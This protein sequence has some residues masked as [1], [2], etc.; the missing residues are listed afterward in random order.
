MMLAKKG[1]EEEEVT[2]AE[3]VGMGEGMGE[4]VGVG[5][6]EGTMEEEMEGMGEA[7]ET[8]DEEVEGMM[9]EEVG[10]G[11]AER[12]AEEEVEGMGE[13]V[14]MGGVVK[15]EGAVEEEVEGMMGLG[16][17]EGMVVNVVVGG[18]GVCNHHVGGLRSPISRRPSVR[19]RQRLRT[20]NLLTVS[21]STQSLDHRQHALWR[22]RCDWVAMDN[23]LHLG[24]IV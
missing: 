2:V 13:A 9:A 19:T 18:M 8:V 16:M 14:G 4:A 5:K 17:G 21:K 3:E 6:A 1:V 15:A 11:K 24:K 7:E 22:N 20:T 10:V 23:I 12:T